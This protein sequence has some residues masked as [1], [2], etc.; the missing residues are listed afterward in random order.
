MMWS[1]R[2]SHGF[3]LDVDET[4]GLRQPATSG[5]KIDFIRAI[6][7]GGDNELSH[8]RPLISVDL[9]GLPSPSCLARGRLIQEFF[10]SLFLNGRR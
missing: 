3:W 5:W 7:V 8:I 2:A 6:P 10:P 1:Q 9:E 4:S